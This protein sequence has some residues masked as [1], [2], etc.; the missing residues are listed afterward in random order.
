VGRS[1]RFESTWQFC[2][3]VPEGLGEDVQEVAARIRF[4]FGP[5]AGPCWEFREDA[6]IDKMVMQ[7]MFSLQIGII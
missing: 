1:V 6:V 7:D 2:E 3:L 4:D 5:C